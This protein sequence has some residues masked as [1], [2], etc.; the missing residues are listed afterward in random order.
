[1]VSMNVFSK[2]LC[3]FA[4]DLRADRHSD[5]YCTRSVSL[6]LETSHL[7]ETNESCNTFSFYYQQINTLFQHISSYLTIRFDNISMTSLV[8]SNQLLSVLLFNF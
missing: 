4:I 5:W 8:F 7:L 6:G 3:I 1:M 2:G